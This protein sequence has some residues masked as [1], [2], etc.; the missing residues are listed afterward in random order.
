MY[1]PT[2]TQMINDSIT[3]SSGCMLLLLLCYSA[4]IQFTQTLVEKC[5]THLKKRRRTC[6]LKRK[7]AAQKKPKKIEPKAEQKVNAGARTHRHGQ[8]HANQTNC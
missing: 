6:I 7:F 8:A 5:R 3:F 1:F 2:N 4:I